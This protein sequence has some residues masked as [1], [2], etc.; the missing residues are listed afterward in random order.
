[1][2]CFSYSLQVEVR[3]CVRSHAVAAVACGVLRVVRDAHSPTAVGTTSGFVSSEGT[4]TSCFFLS[5][6]ATVL[7]RRRCRIHA[8]A[9]TI[10]SSNSSPP[11]TLPTDV[12]PPL[13][14]V[15]QA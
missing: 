9:T 5:P 12:P 13:E 11:S 15:R 8:P 6:A 10:N 7:L 2:C 1:M 14:S 4:L 3:I